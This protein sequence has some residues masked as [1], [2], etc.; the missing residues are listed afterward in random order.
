MVPYMSKL[1]DKQEK[2]CH[3]VVELGNQSEAYRG[4]YNAENM[5]AETIHKRSG[6]LMAEGAV[7]GRVQELRDSAIESHGITME[8]L[9]KELEEARTCALTAETVQSSAAV[10]ATMSKA[11]LLGLDK[12]IV[13]HTSS[14]G[15]M[16]PTRIEIVAPSMEDDDD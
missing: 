11:K 10:S 2:F 14:D 7:A 6:E 3:L 13:D 5:K 4:A 12:L 8:S 15:S 1:T 16:S 9:L